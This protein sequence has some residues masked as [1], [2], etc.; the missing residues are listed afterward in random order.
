MDWQ[1]T[2]TNLLAKA[3]D[4][5]ATEE[6]RKAFSE[7]AAYLMAKYGITTLLERPADQPLN[8]VT[9]ELKLGAPYPKVRAQLIFS[10]ARAFNSRAVLFSRSKTMRVFGL[11]EDIDS[12]VQMYASLWIQARFAMIL[13]EKPAHV[14]GKT[15][16]HSYLLGFIDEVVTRVASA[17]ARAAQDANTPE[18]STALVF[19]KRT[20]AVDNAVEIAY[21]NLGRA[22]PTV[23]TG[24][25]SYHAGA[26]AG[27]RADINQPRMG[28]SHSSSTKALLS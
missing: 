12:F 6:E 23:P 19:A 7:R 14:H 8:V 2:V 27:R 25:S 9:I 10:L 24:Y 15:H 16:N 3:Q 4:S 1:K 22:T 26:S 28:G 18:V 21:P 20:T 5:A 17:T 11:Q 13:S